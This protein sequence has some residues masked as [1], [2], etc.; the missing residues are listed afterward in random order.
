MCLAQNRVNWHPT[1]LIQNTIDMR[2]LYISLAVALCCSFSSIA[3]FADDI[4]AYDLGPVFNI[5]WTTWDGEDDGMQNAVVTDFRAHSGEKSVHIG[6]AA[7]ANGGPTDAVLQ[8]GNG[9]TE[10]V[11]SV[12]WM[13]YIPTDSSAYINLQGNVI[14]NANANLEFL[15]GNIYFNQNGDS[16]GIGSDEAAGDLNPFSFPN[17]EWFEM[18]ITVNW[19]YGIYQLTIDG[20]ST[21][22]VPIPPQITTWGGV[23]FFALN[24]NNSYYLDDVE[25]FM[26]P[27]SVEEAADFEVA[28][29]PNPADDYLFISSGIELEK[30][31]IYDI[32]GKEVFSCGACQ[33]QRVDISS[34]PSGYYFVKYS[35][36]EL[37]KTVKV[38]KN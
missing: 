10:G 2:K 36:G 38:L 29:Y 30:V 7:S 3:Q 28:V 15:S 34:I 11:W 13:M 17:D 21:S 9:I 5:L 8:F 33:N 25:L 31:G 23:D 4:E 35:V 1:L 37:E 32:L 12:K 27:L 26:D 14:P 24:T 20:S 22:S 19:D 18:M 16:N 6:P